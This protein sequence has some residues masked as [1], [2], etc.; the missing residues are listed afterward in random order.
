MPRS[1]PTVLRNLAGYEDATFEGLGAFEYT[2]RESK[3]E[4]TDY[5]NDLIRIIKSL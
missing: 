2:H 3:R 1:V 5:V 4:I